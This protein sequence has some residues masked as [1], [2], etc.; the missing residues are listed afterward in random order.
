MKFP[1][2]FE[3]YK[4]LYYYIKLVREFEESILRLYRQSK[5][6]GG[7]F[8]GYGNEATSVG[9]AFCL[10]K[11]DYL[12]P[13][14]RDIGAHFVKGQSVKKIMAQHL[15]RATGPAKG[16]DGT[17]HYADADLRI[18][19]NISHL[20]AMIPM[21]TGMALAS[22]LKKE[23]SV[24]LT[25]IGDGGSSIGDFHESLVMASVMKLPLILIIE[26]NQYAYSTPISKQFNVE[27]LSDRA[28]GYG[29]PGFTIDGTDVE[30]VIKITNEACE[31]ARN[32][33]GPTLIESITMR[34]HGHSAHD[35][36]EYVPKELMN[37]WKE[38]DP[39][40]NFEK[41]LID[42]KIISNEFKIETESKIKKE[43]DEAIE[44][45]LNSPFPNG[46]D[47]LVGLFSE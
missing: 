6:V 34:M 22:K 19:G 17:G 1:L 38:K 27:K 33:D 2:T 41:K 28:I 31:R 44:F 42:K 20:G 9:S 5:I 39:V 14:H 43:I 46:E 23:K 4:S 37:E 13:M 15:A 24:A 45:A 25:Y 18:F 26:N 12:F 10:N 35:G 3:D 21:A 29:I 36:A 8:T 16:R 30:E 40:I 11:N 47:A 32:G 7:A